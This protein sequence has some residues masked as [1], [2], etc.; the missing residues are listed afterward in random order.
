MSQTMEQYEISINRLGN[1]ILLLEKGFEITL[2]RSYNDII[3]ILNIFEIDV[4]LESIGVNEKPTQEQID[5]ILVYAKELL[6][7]Y[8]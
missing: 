3:K 5:E 8:I 4:E 7:G 6:N 1:Y 2:R